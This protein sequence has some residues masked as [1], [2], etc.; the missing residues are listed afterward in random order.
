MVPSTA[1]IAWM[2]AWSLINAFTNPVACLLASAAHL[3][4]QII[5]SA[6]STVANIVLSIILVQRWGV[7][8]VIAATVISYS[9]FICVPCY[10]D[11]ERLLGRLRHA[12]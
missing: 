9:F 7:E 10:L 3:R 2:A 4:T 1:L 12:V 5:Y 11:A 6:F 8:G